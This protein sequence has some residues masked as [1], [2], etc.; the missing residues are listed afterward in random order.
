VITESGFID[1]APQAWV[2]A[3]QAQR[4]KGLLALDYLTAVDQAGSVE[5]L[6][7]LVTPGS[8]DEAMLRAVLPGDDL[9]IAT[10]LTVYPGADWHER[11]TSEMFGIE[12]H[13][14]VGTDPLLL[15]TSSGRPPLRR[16]SPLPERVDTPWP[17]AQEKQRRRRLPPGVRKEWVDPDE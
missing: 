15:R 16:D 2:S 14:R 7:H 9:R 11:E 8:S 3:A 4:E 13:G 6:A 1:V 10:L 5:V 12:F 17:G